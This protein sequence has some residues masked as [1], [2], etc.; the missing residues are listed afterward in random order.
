MDTV[1]AERNEAVEEMMGFRS[2]RWV[3]LVLSLLNHETVAGFSDVT[4]L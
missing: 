4:S 1:T 3:P 2:R